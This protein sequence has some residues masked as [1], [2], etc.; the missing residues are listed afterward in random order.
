MSLL[1]RFAAGLLFSLSMLSGSAH[2]T[3]YSTDQSDLW[4]APSESGWGMQMVQRNSLI[5]ATIYIYSNNNAP[6]WYTALLSPTSSALTWSGDLF[7]T[8]GPWF[9]AP[10]YNPATVGI[11]KVGAMTWVASSVDSGVLTYSVD[12]VSVI[13]NLERFPFPMDNFAGTYLGASATTTTQCNKQSN[14]GTLQIA[15]TTSVTQN[16]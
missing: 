8:S 16:G 3:A 4:W 12:G 15:G 7:L 14:N 11:R 5:F 1:Q 9:G 2:A 6:V 10:T 13:K